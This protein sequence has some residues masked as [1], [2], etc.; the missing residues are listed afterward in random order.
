M[1]TN[2]AQNCYDEAVASLHKYCEKETDLAAVILDEEYPFR[3]QFVPDYQ[4]SVEG[5][6]NIDENGEVNDLTVT[7]GLTTSVKSTLKFRMPSDQL[8]KLIK[9]SEKVGNIYYHAFREEA[10]DLRADPADEELQEML[11]GVVGDE[12]GEEAGGD[13]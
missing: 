6:E 11:R 5:N 12:D 1:K 8:K 7:V 10:G 2:A 4:M 13:V 3:V 9:L